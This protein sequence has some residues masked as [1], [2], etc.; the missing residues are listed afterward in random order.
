MDG[1]LRGVPILVVE[2]DAANAKLLSILLRDAGAV[3]VVAR[4]AA[5]AL[6]AVKGSHFRL[7]VLDLVLP[8]MGGLVLVDQLRANE[9]NRALPV[10]A[11]TAVTGPEV[12]RIVL[13]AGCVAYFRKPIETMAFVSALVPLLGGA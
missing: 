11:V 4:D 13:A 5:E 10:V 3:V 12:K 9:V 2:D 6:A 1:R 7:V 8:G